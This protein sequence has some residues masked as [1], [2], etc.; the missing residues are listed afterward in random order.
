MTALIQSRYPPLHGVYFIIRLI[1]PSP[2]DTTAILFLRFTEAMKILAVA[3]TPSF[4]KR[5]SGTGR[6]THPAFVQDHP[7]H[8]AWGHVYVI[9]NALGS[10]ERVQVVLLK[11]V[12]LPVA[13]DARHLARHVPGHI[14]VIAQDPPLGNRGRK[15]V[16]QARENPVGDFLR[17]GG[18]VVAAAAWIDGDFFLE[19]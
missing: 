7:I 8:H 9:V 2:K 17:Q 5:R 12:V 18:G 13:D 10:P 15:V 6:Q 4:S 14:R 11:V 19:K 3:S 16:T 1:V